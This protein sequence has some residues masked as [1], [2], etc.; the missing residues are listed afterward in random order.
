LTQQRERTGTLRIFVSYS[1][2]DRWFAT[3][4]LDRL[5]NH[6]DVSVF[7][8]QNLSAAGDYRLRLKE[9]L[10][11]AGAFLV[12]LSPRSVK[13]NWVLY[14]LGAAWALGK[15]LVAVLTDPTV[16]PKIPVEARQL[17]VVYV[18]DPKEPA[19]VERILKHLRHCG[20]PN[21]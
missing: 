12:L 5:A 8:T 15:P 14:E 16:R 6:P 17:S 18:E 4:L 1:S 11:A 2:E 20:M 7:A 19:A 9:E 3:L 13:S 21:P 10:R